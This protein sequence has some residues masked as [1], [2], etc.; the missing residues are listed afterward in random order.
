MTCDRGR[1]VALGTEDAP[2]LQAFLDLNPRYSQIVAGRPWLPDEAL[3]ELTETPPPDWPQGRTWKLALL[4]PDGDCQGLLV[5]SEDLLA[6]GVW[7]LGL[8][9]IDERL[10]RQGLARHW[11]DAFERHARACGARWVR[12]GVVVGNAPAE[13]FWSARGWAE[14]KRRE[15][16]QIGE[17]VQDLRVMVKPLAG[18]ANL[19]EYLELVSRDRP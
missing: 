7:H 1:A 8:L 13:A 10:Q 4:G 2:Q 14:A 15:G 6:H 19:D 3:Q 16:V 17:L 12:L 5:Y 9:L 18:D 11:V